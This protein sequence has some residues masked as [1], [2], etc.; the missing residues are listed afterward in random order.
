MLLILLSNKFQFNL[1]QPTL[2]HYTIIFIENT[3]T[4]YFSVVLYIPLFNF[5]IFFYQPQCH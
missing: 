5:T 1:H 2:L 4:D 3:I